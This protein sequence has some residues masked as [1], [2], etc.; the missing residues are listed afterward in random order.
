MRV[1]LISLVLAI[2]AAPA[3]AQP[4]ESPRVRLAQ[5]HDALHLSAAQQAAWRAYEVALRPDPRGEAQEESAQGMMAS[6]TTPRRIALMEAL[7]GARAAE[8]RRWGAATV[9]FYDQL[10]P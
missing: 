2:C 5:L 4:L 7:M 6:L 9:S 3:L 1:L 10:T 8:L